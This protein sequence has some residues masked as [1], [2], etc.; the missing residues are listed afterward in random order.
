M[1]KKKI[2]FWTTA[3][4]IY[5]VWLYVFYRIG[6]VL[7]FSAVFFAFIVTIATMGMIACIRVLKWRYE[8][9][10]DLFA[11]LETDKRTVKDHMMFI[12]QHGHTEGIVGAFKEFNDIFRNYPQ[13]RL[14][15]WV[16]FRSWYKDQIDYM[17]AEPN[18]YRMSMK[19]DDSP[20]SKEKDH[21]YDPDAPAWET[22]KEH[23]VY[24][25]DDDDSDD[26]GDGS[27][28]IRKSAEEGAEM[29]IGIGVAD[30]VSDN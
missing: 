28:S 12:M 17:Y 27:Y 9:G 29:G 21:L 16:V 6:G 26:Y 8:N 2:I 5:A 11:T 15:D 23:R 22:F 19:Y 25:D 24:E 1:N 20:Y 7:D 10:V 18:I 30:S 14:Q 13:W 3:T 4:A